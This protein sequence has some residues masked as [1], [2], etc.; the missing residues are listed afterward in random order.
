[1]APF[2]GDRLGA[3]ALDPS[4]FDALRRVI[5]PQLELEPGALPADA[6][7]QVLERLSACVE[8][9]PVMQAVVAVLRTELG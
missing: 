9:S 4:D 8:P 1:M 6:R 7:Q 2:A 3:P 5:P